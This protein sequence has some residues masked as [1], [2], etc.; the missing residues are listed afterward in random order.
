MSPVS[1]RA[2]APRPRTRH[3]RRLPT[4]PRQAQ[5]N[6][7]CPTVVGKGVSFRL[8]AP[9][10]ACRQGRT[11]AR[12][13]SVSKWA[14]HGHPFAPPCA[15]WATQR[16]SIAF[17][18]VLYHRAISISPHLS[19][20]RLI[21][22]DVHSEPECEPDARFLMLDVHLLGCVPCRDLG[23]FSP[24]QTK[25][26][27]IAYTRTCTDPQPTQQAAQ[28]SQPSACVT[29]R[30]IATRRHARPVL[31]T[32]LLRLNTRKVGAALAARH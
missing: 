7:L 26:I 25:H 14:C 12:R 23:R 18:R 30:R 31:A 8:V 11:S 28:I 21:S 19:S 32:V 29:P 6:E 5:H 15:A 13:A 17:A 2:A 1:L 4:S 10:L 3:W 9:G 20:M 24:I 27:P 22:T 16:A